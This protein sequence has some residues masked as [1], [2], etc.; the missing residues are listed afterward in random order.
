MTP[1]IGDVVHTFAFRGLYDGVS[2]LTDY[3]T[4]SYWNHI[5]GRAMYGPLEGAELAVGNLLHMSVEQALA[6]DPDMRVAIS[7]RPIRGEQSRFWPLAKVVPVLSDRAR[8][9]MA[10]EDTRRPTLD[11]GLGA[12]TDDEA[13]YYPM[14]HVTAAGDVL[15][16]E[17]AG[18]R[19]MVYFDPSGHALAAVY[20]DATAA[21]WD[22][23][24]LTLD[25]GESIEGGVLYDEG[26]ER[27]RMERPLQMFT[28]WYGFALT[29]PETGVYEP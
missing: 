8:S 27:L 5:T 12:W 19:L 16:D 23:R 13:R 14:E 10:G 6:T 3:E 7:D 15:F 1:L 18:R 11:V 26:G 24:K 25:T 28:R 17:L 29:F 20:T 9:T 4:E 21:R 22:G 2:L